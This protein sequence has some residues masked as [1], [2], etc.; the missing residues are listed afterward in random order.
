VADVLR[1]QIT[2]GVFDGLLPDER[3]LGERLGA[4]RNA[5]REALGLLPVAAATGSDQCGSE[6]RTDGG[7]PRDHPSFPARSAILPWPMPS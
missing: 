3:A 2:S 1:H 7:D 6:T 4:S 5:V